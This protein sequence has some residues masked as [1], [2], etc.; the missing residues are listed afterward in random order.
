MKRRHTY[1]NKRQSIK[2]KIRGGDGSCNNAVSL[3][4][5]RRH[6]TKNKRNNSVKKLKKKGGFA[7]FFNNFIPVSM[8]YEGGISSHSNLPLKI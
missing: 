5:G 7:D 6:K 8:N 3:K 4:G 2:N 1:K